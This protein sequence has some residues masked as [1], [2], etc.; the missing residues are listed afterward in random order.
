MICRKLIRE[1]KNTDIHLYGLKTNPILKGMIKISP[2]MSCETLN[3]LLNN[4]K[5]ISGVMIKTEIVRISIKVFCNGRTY[6]KTKFIEEKRLGNCITRISISK[7]T[8]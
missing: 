2:F 3:A 5:I 1:I 4:E 8:N 6:I 7:P